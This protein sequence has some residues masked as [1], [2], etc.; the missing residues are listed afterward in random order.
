MLA[1]AFGFSTDTDLE[2]RV[3]DNRLV[4][5]AERDGKID[6]ATWGVGPVP[7]VEPLSDRHLG[8][9]LRIVSDEMAKYPEGFLDEYLDFVYL[10]G[11]MGILGVE[12]YGATYDDRRIFIASHGNSDVWLREAFHHELSSLLLHENANDFPEEAWV[13][14]NAGT[15][16]VGYGTFKRHEASI[17]WDAG[18]LSLRERGFFKKYSTVSVEE[19]FNTVVEALFIGNPDLWEAYREYPAMQKK[20]TIAVEFLNELHPRFDMTFFRSLRA[21]ND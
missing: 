18:D 6:K 7:Q 15:R 2:I 14:A 5:I 1:T 12:E 10:A 4:V 11:S 19:D 13:A 17:N 8:R 9:M 3:G 16:Y 20:V 21:E